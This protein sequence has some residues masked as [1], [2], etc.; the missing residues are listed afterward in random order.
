MNFNGY[1][2]IG[3]FVTDTKRSLRFYVD[4]LGGKETFS[5]P[6]PGASGDN[7]I[8]LVD[9]GGGAVIEIIPRGEEQAEERARWA[10]ICLLTDD[11]QAAYDLAIKAGA[12][13]RSEPKEAMLGTMK[14]VNA[15]V[16]GPDGEVVEFFKVI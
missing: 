6:M 16:Y 4:G 8:Y 14:A 10:H 11:V 13:S 15:F 3:L 1:H 12:V 5:F 9:L 7:T 2:H